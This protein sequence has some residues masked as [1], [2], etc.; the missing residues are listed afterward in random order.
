MDKYWKRITKSARGETFNPLIYPSLIGTLV[1]GLGFTVFS[2]VDSIHASS[3]F[4]AMTSIHAVIPV[5]WGGIAV[6]TIVVGVIFLLW[7]K[8]PAGK[9]SGLMGFMLWV[10]AGFCWY[11]TGAGF[12][13]L[14]VA[15]PNIWFWIWQYLSLAAFRRE[16]IED[17]ANG[18]IN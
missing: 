18:I 10:F 12:V 17:A 9:L 2:W 3:L 8:P 16:E 6:A 5:I 13:T 4:I 11:L 15:V 7:N 1:Y 14:A